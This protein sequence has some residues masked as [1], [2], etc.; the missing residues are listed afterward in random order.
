MG[1]LG[2]A[3]RDWNCDWVAFS[4]L[5]RTMRPGKLLDVLEA[6]PLAV[7]LVGRDP[8]HGGD[9]AVGASSALAELVLPAPGPAAG[10]LDR[11]ALR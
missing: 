9:L 11:G 8:L 3:V 7:S 6:V 4:R 10:R 1:H 2:G 5:D